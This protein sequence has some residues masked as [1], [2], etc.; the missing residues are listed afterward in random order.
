[1]WHDVP[2]FPEPSVYFAMIKDEGIFAD[3][4]AILWVNKCRVL[5]S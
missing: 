2:N 3:R 5:I 1:M 4:K